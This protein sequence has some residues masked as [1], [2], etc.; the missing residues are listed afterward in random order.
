MDTDQSA[1]RKW[2]FS[3]DQRAE[4]WFDQCIKVGILSAQRYT[5]LEAVCIFDGNPNAPLVN[6]LRDHGVTVLIHE[7]PFKSELFSDKVMEA[8]AGSPYNPSQAAG[9]YLRIEAAKLITDD[10]FLY[11]DCDVMFMSDPAVHFVRPELI[12]ACPEIVLNGKHF[13]ETSSFN[14]GVLVVN[15]EA[16]LN[17]TQDLVEYCRKNNFYNKQYSSYDQ[18]LLNKYFEGRWS[19]LSPFLNWRPFQG[20]S[21]EASIIHFHGPKPHRISKILSGEAAESEM[22][23]MLPLIQDHLAEYEHFVGIFEEFSAKV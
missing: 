21:P 8:N 10:Y 9:A 17:T 4:R 16:F 7:V 19:R 5:S 1:V 14:S 18:Y 22:Q 12:G 23:G 15:R 3:L 13:G 11:T 6:W 20:P 2:V